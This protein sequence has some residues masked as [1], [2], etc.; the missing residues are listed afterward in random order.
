M[1]VSF[2]FPQQQ[3]IQQNNREH[4]KINKSHVNKNNFGKTKPC[5]GIGFSDTEKFFSSKD[6]KK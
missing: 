2:I 5:N 4:N 6:R 3:P 1:Q